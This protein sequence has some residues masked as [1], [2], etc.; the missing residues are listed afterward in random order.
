MKIVPVPRMN[1]L[2]GA[3]WAAEYVR[4]LAARSDATK[5]WPPD[6]DDIE[7]AIDDA[8]ETVLALRRRVEYP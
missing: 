1:Q 2:E 3:V 8:N 4:Y 5:R 7:D 6:D